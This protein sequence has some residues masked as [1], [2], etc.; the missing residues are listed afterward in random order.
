MNKSDIKLSNI[1]NHYKKLKATS[2]DTWIEFCAEQKN[3]SSAIKYAALATNKQKKRHPH[4]YR[5]KNV[6]L[7]VFSELLQSLEVEIAKVKTFDELFLIV[8]KTSIK[9]IGELAKYDTVTRIAAYLKLEPEKIYLHAGTKKGAINLLNKRITTKTIN[10]SDLP[11][12][13]SNLSCSE[14]E[15]ILCIYKDRLKLLQAA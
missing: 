10:K 3:L 1:I 15:D 12:I 13:F 4:Q 8:T 11:N 9:G 7:R 2:P 14:I 5:L 6:D